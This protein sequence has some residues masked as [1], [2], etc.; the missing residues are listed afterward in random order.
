MVRYRSRKLLILIFPTS[1]LDL[2]ISTTVG[3]VLGHGPT[4]LWNDRIQILHV[5]LDGI[6][7]GVYRHFCF[8]PPHLL[9]LRWP[10]HGDEKSG[11]GWYIT[12]QEPRGLDDLLGQLLVKRI[13]VT[14][15]LSNTKNP[16]YLSQK[17]RYKVVRNWKCTEWPLTDL[18]HFTVKSTLYTLN[19]YPW[20]PN[21]GPFGSTI[22]RFRETTCKRSAKIGNAQD[23]SKLNLNT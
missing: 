14:F 3:H 8:F 23:D 15:Q 2:P 10:I 21:F 18:G 4:L 22:S 5:S 1:H 11:L 7:C 17:S 9:A 20:G 12:E 16:E 13:P 6:P 19:T